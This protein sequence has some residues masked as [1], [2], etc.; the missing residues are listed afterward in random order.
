MGETAVGERTLNRVASMSD[1]SANL[2]ANNRY[3]LRLNISSR[4]Y[5]LEDL[6]LQRMVNGKQREKPLLKY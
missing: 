5:C 2:V 4:T 3:A 1:A 6:S